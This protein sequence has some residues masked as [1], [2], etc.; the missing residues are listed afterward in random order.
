M[1][2]RLLVG[3]IAVAVFSVA[4]SFAFRPRK[5]SV[6][7]HKKEYLKAADRLSENTLKHKLQRIAFRVTG[8][9]LRDSWDANAYRSDAKTL[10]QHQASLV[11][12][13]YLAKG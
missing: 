4:V 12:L 9:L 5:G 8:W 13:G 3:A 2:K 7:W 11:Q 6:Q 10:E 1:R